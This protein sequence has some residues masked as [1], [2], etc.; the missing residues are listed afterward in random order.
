MLWFVIMT[1]QNTTVD[2]SS[3]VYNDLLLNG[4]VFKSVTKTGY[5]EIRF[6][7]A[8][9]CVVKEGSKKR[10]LVFGHNQDCC[11]NVGIEQIDGDLSDLEGVPLMMAQEAT[12]ENPEPGDDCSYFTFYKFATIKGYVTVRWLGESNGYY[13]T[14]VDTW[15]LDES[16]QLVYER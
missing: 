10:V 1:D 5:N 2:Q 12:C 8:D 16:N 7:L 6:E 13:S 9:D 14:S 15:W 3:L 4:L 11:E